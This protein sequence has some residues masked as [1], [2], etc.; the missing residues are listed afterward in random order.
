VSA[1]STAVKLF[2]EYLTK[3]RRRER[4]RFALGFIA[5]TVLLLSVL[6]LAGAWLGLYRG[7][8]PQLD[9]LIRG[10][11]VLSVLICGVLLLW[12]PLG[13]LASDD[14]ANNRFC[15]CWPE[16]PCRWPSG[17]P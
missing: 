14:G 1:Q 9:L 17:Y 16:M 12:R 6:T 11:M 15:L 8:T 10:I 5:L 2:S 4:W 7:F 3:A 13:K